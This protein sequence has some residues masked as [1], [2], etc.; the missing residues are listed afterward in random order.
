MSVFVFV[1]NISTSL[2][3]AINSSAT[4]LT[5]ASSIGLPTLATG[6]IMPLTLNDAATGLV[7]EV[8]Y[9]T[10]ISGSTLT[11][12]RA[13]EGTSAQNWQKGDF[14]LC[15]PT[16]GTVAPAGKQM[17]VFGY[18]TSTGSLGTLTPTAGVYSSVIIPASI[19]YVRVWGGGGGGVLNA[20]G[21]YPFAGGGAGGEYTEG[22]ISH[23][24]TSSVTI[25]VGAGGAG[26]VS[27]VSS[28]QNGTGSSFGSLITVQGG[29]AGNTSGGGLGAASGT[30]GNLHIA[31]GS[32]SAGVESST[33][34][35]GGK[36]GD[37]PMG[38]PGGA[39]GST[40]NGTINNGQV[41]GGGGASC[42]ISTGTAGNGANGMVIVVW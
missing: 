7:Y 13:Q 22:Y 30:G 16:A 15:C 32:G 31:G 26:N 5:L 38:G 29:V 42:A 36:G 3:S 25:T 24:A 19:L 17:Q 21:G 41:P 11:V 10:A 35:F 23:T 18:T 1:N 12:T 4:S 37:S 33:M 6:Q 2:A 34:T 14:A 40:T 20:I 8:V 39:G 28:A 9:A 27:G